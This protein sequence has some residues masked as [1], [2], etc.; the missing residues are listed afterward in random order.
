MG[1]WLGH[2]LVAPWRLD[3]H[4]LGL[5]DLQGLDDPYRDIHV[6]TYTHQDIYA[7]IDSLAYPD[8]Y[9]ISHANAD[10]N[11]DSYAYAHPNPNADSFPNLHADSQSGL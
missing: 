6:N 11:K 10:S 5:A 4:R 8:V 7:N 3:V 2:G 9:S 1:P